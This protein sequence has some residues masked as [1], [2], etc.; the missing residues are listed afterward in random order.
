M[1]SPLILVVV[2]VASFH[3]YSAWAFP[4]ALRQA[5]EYMTAIAPTQA[6]ILRGLGPTLSHKA[7]IYFPGSQNFTS[8]TARWSV[9]G[10]PDIHVVVEPG[11]DDDVAA[12]V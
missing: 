1:Y 8:A 11:D 12:A 2:V 6:Q 7:S 5:V 9:Y 4:F 10:T 3:A